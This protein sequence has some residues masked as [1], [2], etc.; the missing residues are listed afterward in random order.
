MIASKFTVVLTVWV[1]VVLVAHKDQVQDVKKL[2]DR[3]K[4]EQRCEHLVHKQV[5][6]PWGWY[7]GIDEGERFHRGII[8][9]GPGMTS[10]VIRSARPVRVGTIDE[11]DAAD[12]GMAGLPTREHFGVMSQLNL[13]RV[14]VAPLPKI[15]DRYLHA[16]R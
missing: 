16:S 5:Y 3:L 13:V 11:Q 8:Q 14:L 6:R 9:L 2:V 7:E 15:D 12:L 10:R 4:A 1:L